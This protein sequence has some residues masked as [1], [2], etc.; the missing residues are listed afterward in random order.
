ML[1]LTIFL[2]FVLCD[3]NVS[4]TEN[5]FHRHVRMNTNKPTYRCDPGGHKGR[6]FQSRQISP[7]TLDVSI[8]K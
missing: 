6:H 8:F 5:T 7:L 3:N 2:R 1:F 4:W